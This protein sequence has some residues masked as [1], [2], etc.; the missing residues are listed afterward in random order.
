MVQQNK[1][2]SVRTSMVLPQEQWLTVLTGYKKYSPIGVKGLYVLLDRFYKEL[3]EDFIY[4]ALA[5][6]IAVMLSIVTCRETIYQSLWKA[7]TI[8]EKYSVVD[9]R[10]GFKY[11]SDFV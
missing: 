4:V 11:A 5:H 6:V 7:L 8:F 10:L 1:N 2:D 9:V 3:F